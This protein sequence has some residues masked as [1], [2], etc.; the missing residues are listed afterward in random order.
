M[1]TS[2]EIVV[3]TGGGHKGIVKFQSVDNGGKAV[4]GSCCLDFRPSGAKLYMI[5]GNI[6]EIALNDINTAF[7]VPFWVN[8]DYGC[9]V[10]SRTVTM[11]GGNMTKPEMMRRIDEYMDAEERK[12][13]AA[14]E[15]SASRKTDVSKVDGNKKAQ[16]QILTEP[17]SAETVSHS[18]LKSDEAEIEEM[19]DNKTRRAVS[20]MKEIEEWVK[21]DGNNFYYAVKP[22]L[23]EMFVCYPQEDALNN[24]VQNSQWVRVDAED[25]YY[26]VGLLFND[27]EPAYIC[28]GVPAKS[29]T[30]PPEELENMCVWLPIDDDLGYWVIYQSAIN[31]AIVR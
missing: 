12:R 15:S 8:S 16:T 11:F 6:T 23:D 14:S 20:G 1:S 30:R 19:K 28:Y 7:E 18:D 31:G 3:I 26:V 9:V 21:Y 13:Q 5:G 24:A 4:K 22:Q 27:S 17:E 25:G 29:G 10:R 2:K